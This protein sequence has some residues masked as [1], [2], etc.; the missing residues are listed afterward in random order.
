M[1][2]S[3]LIGTKYEILHK[4]IL[5]YVYNFGEAIFF[6]LLIKIHFSDVL[7]KPYSKEV[8]FAISLAID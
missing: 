7:F 1:I 3:V 6:Y 5:I 2:F 8:R 4:T